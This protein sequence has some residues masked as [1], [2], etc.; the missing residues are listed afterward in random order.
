MRRFILALVLLM[1][2]WLGCGSDPRNPDYV[3]QTTIPLHPSPPVAAGGPPRTKAP[4]GQP[5]P[6]EPPTKPDPGESKKEPG[7]DQP[8]D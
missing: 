3:P 1:P 8:K 6:Q 7:Q 4:A 2:G 5:K